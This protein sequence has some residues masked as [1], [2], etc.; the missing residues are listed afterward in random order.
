M[1]GLAQKR[2]LSSPLL[3][4]TPPTLSSPRVVTIT[5]TDASNRTITLADGEDCRIDFTGPIGYLPG[6]YDAAQDAIVTVIGGRHVVVM[7]AQF[8]INSHAQ[9][10][11]TADASAVATTLTVAST[12]GFPDEGIVRVAGEAIHYSSKTATTFTIA[13]R[14]FGFFLG[15]GTPPL[16]LTAG[17]TVYIG[18]YARGGLSFRSQTGTVHV[19]GALIE[20]TSLI[21]A[22]RFRGSSMTARVQNFRFGPL[23]PADVPGMTDGHADGIQTWGAGPISVSLS[24]GTVLSGPN[25]RGLINAANTSGGGAVGTF[26]VRDCE[27]VDFAGRRNSIVTNSD[28]GTTWVVRNAWLRTVRTRVVA[29]PEIGD[30][31][32]QALPTDPG[33]LIPAAGLGIG[34][35]SPGYAA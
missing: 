26:T 18:E 5:P 25:G 1:I 29:A 23:G 22:L 4:W 17:T 30:L 9:T 19:E 31:F 27:F 2:K 20:G 11:L 6:P 16:A 21:D 33:D 3:P 12:A 15:T 13:D 28:S 7:G 24:H 34:Y 32:M 8:A 10:T 35:V 14:N